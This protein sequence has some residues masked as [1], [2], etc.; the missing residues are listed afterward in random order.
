MM[1]AKRNRGGAFG[2]SSR[3]YNIYGNKLA[4]QRSV[5]SKEH[6]GGAHT[7]RQLAVCYPWE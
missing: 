2:Q 6:R 4:Q 7:I 1:N 5:R 3:F